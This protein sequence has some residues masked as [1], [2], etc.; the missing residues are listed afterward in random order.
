[1]VTRQEVVGGLL[2]S[3]SYTMALVTLNWGVSLGESVFF[4]L[5]RLLLLVNGTEKVH[6]GTYIESSSDDD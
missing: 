1:M 4:L 3:C 6:L 5:P 2:R